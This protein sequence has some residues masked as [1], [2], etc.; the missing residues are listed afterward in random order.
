MFLF[1]SYFYYFLPAYSPA[2]LLSCALA[3]LRA[4]ERARDLV[5]S[6]YRDFFSLLSILFDYSTLFAYYLQLALLYLVCL[7]SL[8]GLLAF[9]T[10]I[11][12]CI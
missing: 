3:R 6:L 9:S 10:L 8:A 11:V 5:V 7:L 4:C 12:C 1:S 2:C